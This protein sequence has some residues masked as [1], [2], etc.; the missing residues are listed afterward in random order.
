MER[1]I[2]A[3]EGP[4][5]SREFDEL[6]RALRDSLNNN[7]FTYKKALDKTINSLRVIL[8]TTKDNFKERRIVVN[9][10]DSGVDRC[11]QVSLNC[12]ISRRASELDILINKV[13]VVIHEDTLLLT[14]LKNAQE[15]ALPEAYLQPRKGVAYICPITRNLKHFLLPK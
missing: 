5:L 10:N 3:A 15:A 2:R 1:L 7:L 9:I 6:L 11:M 13:R 8:V 12:L 14:E 4:S